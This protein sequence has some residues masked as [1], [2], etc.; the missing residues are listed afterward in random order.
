VTNT[1]VKQTFE[2]LDVSVTLLDIS[3]RETRPESL[4]TQYSVFLLYIE[5]L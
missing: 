2:W 4:I 5:F 1:F 3:I